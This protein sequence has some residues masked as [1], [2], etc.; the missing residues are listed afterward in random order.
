[1]TPTELHKLHAELK[2]LS[3]R[4]L[5]S[6][7]KVLSRQNRKQL[8]Y[9]LDNKH[10]NLKCNEDYMIEE[11]IYN[12]TENKIERIKSRMRNIIRQSNNPKNTKEF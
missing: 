3:F 6:L 2:I 8:K 7:L 10:L 1:M 12:V 4:D 9:L 11:E 5:S